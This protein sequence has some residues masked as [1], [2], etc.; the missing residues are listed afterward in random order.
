MAVLTFDR[1]IVVESRK[2]EK[3]ERVKFYATVQDSTGKWNLESSSVDLTALPLLEPVSLSCQVTGRVYAGNGG[4][5]GAF[6]PPRQVILVEAVKQGTPV[7][8]ASSAS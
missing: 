5:E 3:S 6:V 4:A 1:A 8:V 2:S 7:K